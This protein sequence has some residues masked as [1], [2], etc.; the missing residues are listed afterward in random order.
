MNTPGRGI[1]ANYRV[2]DEPANLLGNRKDD[3]YLLRI[4]QLRISRWYS[5]NKIST[6][7]CD[8]RRG[9]GTLA[10][11]GSSYRFELYYLDGC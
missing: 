7:I 11:K 4:R 9:V 6:V 10:I 5:G 3:V 1:E 2:K 8:R